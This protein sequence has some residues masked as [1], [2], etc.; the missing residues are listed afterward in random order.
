MG[1]SAYTM[2]LLALGIVL[3]LQLAITMNSFEYQYDC[4]QVEWWQVF[5]KWCTRQTN[6]CEVSLA[7]TSAATASQLLSVSPHLTHVQFV[8]GK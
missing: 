3:L 5:P 7:A 2:L 4:H 1:V 8:S 6:W